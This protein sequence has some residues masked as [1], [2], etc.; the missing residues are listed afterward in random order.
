MPDKKEK[1]IVN[2]ISTVYGDIVIYRYYSKL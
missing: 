1:K 2:I